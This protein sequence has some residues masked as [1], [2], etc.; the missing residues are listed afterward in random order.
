MIRSSE[1]KLPRHPASSTN[2]HATKARGFSGTLPATMASGNNSA[3][4]RMR[5]TEMPST[6]RCQEIPSDGAHTC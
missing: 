1:T 2:I 6:P 4:M 3:A 5:K